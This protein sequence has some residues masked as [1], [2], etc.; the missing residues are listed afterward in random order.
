MLTAFVASS[1]AKGVSLWS[2][3]AVKQHVEK[4]TGMKVPL[5]LVLSVLKKQFDLSY[6]RIKRVQG[7]GDSERNKVLRSLFAQKMLQLYAQGAHVVNIDE[8]WI[9]CSDFRRSCW[10]PRGAGN[11]M[12]DTALS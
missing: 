12:H 4:A 11:T 10:G 6:K 2:A 7:V 9:P 5:R 1:L 8:S 3:K